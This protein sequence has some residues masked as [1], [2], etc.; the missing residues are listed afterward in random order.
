MHLD[1]YMTFD[2]TGLAAL[3]TAGRSRP[4]SS[5]TWRDDACAR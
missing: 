1:E 5:S 3:V 4:P 2:A